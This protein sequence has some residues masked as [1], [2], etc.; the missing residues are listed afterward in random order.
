[1]PTCWA[2]I[3]CHGKHN[4]VISISEL[5]TLRFA[6]AAEIAAARISKQQAAKEEACSCYYS[7]GAEC[8]AG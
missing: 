4:G 2:P 1:M 6:E 8:S 3:H 5:H 7:L